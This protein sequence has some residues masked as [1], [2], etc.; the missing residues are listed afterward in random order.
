MP[1]ITAGYKDCSSKWESL[2]K[3]QS[4][5]NS[6]K[7]R[8]QANGGSYECPG[9]DIGSYTQCTKKDGKSAYLGELI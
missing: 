5:T 8:V 6:G 7:V 2:I 3:D 9:G 1:G 4:S